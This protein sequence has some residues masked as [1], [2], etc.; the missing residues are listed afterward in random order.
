MVQERGDLD[1]VGLPSK[2]VRLKQRWLER[3]CLKRTAAVKDEGIGPAVRLG[4]GEIAQ[5]R[6][7]PPGVSG[8]I[9]ESGEDMRV[10]V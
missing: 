3:N 10:R 2:F 8:V 5:Q 1:L 9:Y 7:G 4:P 6:K